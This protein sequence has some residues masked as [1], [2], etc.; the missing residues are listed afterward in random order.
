MKNNTIAKCWTLAALL[1]FVTATLQIVNEMLARKIEVLP[2][3]IYKSEAKKF[4]IE[5]GKL[6]LPFSSMPG[7][8][9]AAAESLSEVK[10]Q[11]F[12]SI[13]DVARISK[14]SKTVIEELREINAFGDLP[15]SNQ[16]TLF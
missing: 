14:V 1:M 8:G 5:D 6:R 16:M 4:V 13:E 11:S 2:I 15:E 9:E 7:V 12:L 10:H 3:N